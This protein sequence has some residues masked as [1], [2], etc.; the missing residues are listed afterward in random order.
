MSLDFMARVFPAS[1]V[2]LDP[3]ARLLGEPTPGPVTR[4][5]ISAW[6]GL[7]FGSGLALGMTRRPG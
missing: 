4:T 2:T 5:L 6:E 7:C 1:Q 3:L